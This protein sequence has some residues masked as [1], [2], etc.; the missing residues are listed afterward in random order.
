MN[1][2]YK[3]MLN[4]VQ[5]ST[6]YRFHT[7]VTTLQRLI[8]IFVQI[9]LWTALY[10]GAQSLHIEIP[11]ASLVEMW[12]YVV[13][14]SLIGM[15]VSNGNIHSLSDKIQSG[16]IVTTLIRPIGLFRSLLFETLG[17]KV[18]MILFEITPVLI[19][20]HLMFGLPLPTLNMIPIFAVMMVIAFTVFFLMTFIVGMSS[21]WYLRTFHLEFVLNHV[22]NFFSGIMIPI[23]FFP[24]EL[25]AVIEWLPFDLVYFAPLSVWLGKTEEGMG[26]GAMLAKG[27]VWIALLSIAA[28][29]VWNLGKRKLV[30]QGG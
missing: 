3:L 6:A 23:W 18:F 20:S 16:H 30:I 11:Q 1:V 2:Y 14:S 28:V 12:V 26:I 5:S 10:K 19:V 21:F 17:S 15:M 25:R 24:H 29:V 4:V 22:M 8:G 9:C 7:F 13:Y 27:C